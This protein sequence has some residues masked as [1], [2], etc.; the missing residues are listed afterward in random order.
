MVWCSGLQSLKAHCHYIYISVFTCIY[1]YLPLLHSLLVVIL[2]IIDYLSYFSNH[3]DLYPFM[4]IYSP[5]SSNAA[6]RI[7]DLQT[8][9]PI[10]FWTAPS[11]RTLCLDVFA[12][13]RMLWTRCLFCEQGQ[14]CQNMRS[15]NTAPGI[16]PQHVFCGHFPEV[17]CRAKKLKQELEGKNWT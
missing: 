4:V 10:F 12:G 15:R 14:K 7:P 2:P 3:V 1:M 6:W 16:W 8:I 13:R 11:T 9:F 5:V 17:L